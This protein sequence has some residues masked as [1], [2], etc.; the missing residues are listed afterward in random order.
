MSPGPDAQE[1]NVVVIWNSTAG[2]SGGAEDVRRTLET[3]PDVTVFETAS[4]EES[5][6]RVERACKEGAS[7]VIA[8]GG[9]GTVNAVVT[10]L[11]Q[12][13]HD[14]GAPPALAIL[15]LGTGNDLARSLRMP[16]IPEEAI[17][18]CLSGAARPMDVLRVSHGDGEIHR[19]GNM[20]TAGNTGKYLEVL[21]E[22]LKQR[23]GALCYLRGA[24]D[25]LEELEVFS[26]QLVID[27]EPP[28]EIDAL[29]LFLANGRTSGGGM[30]VCA[31]AAL[32]DGLLD[33]LIIQDGTGLDLAGLTVDYLMSDVRNSGIVQHRRCRRVQVSCKSEI[34]LSMD[35]DGAKAKAFTVSVEQGAL[36]AVFGA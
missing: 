23:W 15:P 32:D 30:T 26:L 12:W 31:D 27:D 11:T 18:V 5:L 2:S 29:N 24:V 7:R 10:A 3:R 35:G 16:L 28:Y 20:V 14:H 6:R 8:A 19:A 17:E 22:D 36:Q 9:D 13:T 25:L 34:P 1:S 21:T 33:L 4:R